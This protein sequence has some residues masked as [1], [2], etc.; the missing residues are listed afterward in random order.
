MQPAPVAPLARRV[1]IW[2]LMLPLLA[3]CP[4]TQP[5]PTAAPVQEFSVRDTQAKYYLY[6][7][8]RYSPERPWPL[9]VLC[10]G[11]NPWDSAWLE[12]KEWAGFAEQRGIIIAA[13]ELVGTRGDFPPKPDEQLRRQRQ[14]E[15]TILGVVA[16][17]QAAYSV[18][19]ERIFLHGW[20][21]G[22]YAVLHTGLRHP[23]VFRALSIRQGNFDA[24]YMNDAAANL[25]PW[26]QVYVYYGLSDLIREQSEAAIS[27]LRDHG[28]YVDE[29]QVTGY[30]RRLPPSLAWDYFKELADT[31]P[32]IRLSAATPDYRNPRAV[33]FSIRAVPEA[34]DARWDFGDGGDAAGLSVVHEYSEDGTYAVVARVRIA[35]GKWFRRTLRVTVPRPALGLESGAGP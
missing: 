7:P 33:G 17:V 11:T 24:R 27:W 35:N 32:W 5:L 31:R 6:V 2:G 15:R 8:S 9:I 22:A 10:H 25:D 26:Q 1:L 13:P 18:A 23:D 20:S 28:M 3:G 21:A 16:A 12:M 34:T 29:Y 4:S 19:P 30:H 14:D